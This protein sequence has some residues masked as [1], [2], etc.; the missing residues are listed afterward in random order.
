VETQ[1]T[2]PQQQCTKANDMNH[3]DIAKESEVS[4]W[5][6]AES[7]AKVDLATLRSVWTLT[8]LEF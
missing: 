8:R 1:F 6:E 2:A 5:D 3:S 7:R 4:R